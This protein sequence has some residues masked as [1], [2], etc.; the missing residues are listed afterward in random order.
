MTVFESVCVLPRPDDRLLHGV[1]RVEGRAEHAIAVAEQR[2][3][4][5]FDLADVE[6]WLIL[7]GTRG[8]GFETRKLGFGIR[9]SDSV[10]CCL[11]AGFE[12]D[13]STFENAEASL[14]SA[15]RPVRQQALPLSGQGRID[16]CSYSEAARP[17][18]DPAMGPYT[19]RGR[20]RRRCVEHEHLAR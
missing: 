17:A 11:P 13:G 7:F 15:A 14:A 4:L 6:H 12:D 20:R 18:G 8:S 16:V 3:P 2:R 5:C 9:R 1:F 10:A 19:R